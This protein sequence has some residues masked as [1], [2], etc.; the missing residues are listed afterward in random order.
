MG[1]KSP[2]APSQFNQTRD[3]S[4]MPEP[5]E[6][7]AEPERRIFR[8]TSGEGYGAVVNG[9]FIKVGKG[10]RGFSAS[11]YAFLSDDNGQ[12]SEFDNAADA[13]AWA[14]NTAKSHQGQSREK[15]PV[16]HWEI[17]HGYSITIEAD[18]SGS[19]EAETF[20]L[21]VDSPPDP[22]R[23]FKKFTDLDEAL[24]W[25]RKT[26]DEQAGY[27]ADYEQALRQIREALEALSG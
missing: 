4:S 13:V 26:A 23:N 11:V 6:S 12:Y 5:E 1:V 3:E 15:F 14:V 21:W 24:E 20:P 25:A 19:Y 8:L 16:A 17:R 18:E 27:D 7:R 10:F 2:T 22:L 9:N